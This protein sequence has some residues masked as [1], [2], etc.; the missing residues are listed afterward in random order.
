[1]WTSVS[2]HNQTETNTLFSGGHSLVANDFL[3]LLTQGWS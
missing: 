1:M 3:S 2:S